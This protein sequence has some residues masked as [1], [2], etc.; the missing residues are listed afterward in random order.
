MSNEHYGTGTKDAKLRYG[1]MHTN[2]DMIVA[3]DIRVGTDNHEMGD[4]LEICAMPLNHSYKPH[5]EFPPFHLPIK[6]SFQVD[7]KIANLSKPKFM[8][9]FAHSAHDA[10][11][12]RELFE[13]WWGAI[14]AKPDKKIIPLVYDWP[15]K[16]PW[17]SYWLGGSFEEIFSDTHRDIMSVMHFL[18]DR[19][20]YRGDAVRYK[21]YGFS[22][23]VNY[24]GQEL[25]ERNSLMANC[26]ALS[27]VY[28]FM[29]HNR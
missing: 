11:K 5:Q 14:R 9:E 18:N 15:K 17:I 20:D 29:L 24:S 7:L 19:D 22:A 2:L 16:L 23:M 1:P 3:I 4:L 10:I 26:K 25:L 28:R 27:D 6:P 12:V 8:E 13:T 21:V